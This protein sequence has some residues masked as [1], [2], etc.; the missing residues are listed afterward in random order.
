MAMK[1]KSVIALTLMTASGTAFTADE[2][3]NPS[4]KDASSDTQYIVDK[5]FGN[6]DT[7]SLVLAEST[8][9]VDA[10]TFEPLQGDNGSKGES[11]VVESADSGFFETAPD[12][13]PVSATYAGPTLLTAVGGVNPRGGRSPAVI[14]LGEISVTP[15]LGVRLGHNDNITNAK[16]NKISSSVMNLTPQ[17]VASVD[18]GSHQYSLMYLGD[19]IFIPN[20]TIDNRNT[21]T[22]ELSGDHVFTARNRLNWD[23]AY[24]NGAEARGVTDSS[25][26]AGNNLNP[27][28]YRTYDATGVYRYGANGAKGN[29]ELKAAY[30]DKEYLNNRAI[31]VTRDF[32]SF[33]YGVEFLYR[34]APKTQIVLDVNRTNID[35][36]SSLSTQDSMETKYLIGARWKAMAKTEGYFKVGRG[37]KDF[38]TAGLKTANMTIYES[39]ITWSPRTY[40]VL[41]LSL[42]RNYVDGS[43]ASTPAGESSTAGIRWNHKWK[44]YFRTAASASYNTVDYNSSG[45]TDKTDTYALSALYDAKR[46][47][48]FSLDYSYTNRD[49][50]VNLFSYKTNLIFLSTFISL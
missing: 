2:G 10:G 28:E 39:G 16:R 23:V 19:L 50:N 21:H 29:I 8:D 24:I 20:S 3:A 6:P 9:S 34:A 40:S 38:D 46:W 45:R 41:N 13:S 11:A 44:S 47:L 36:K 27:D 17:I 4:N 7:E 12:T 49:S 1:I 42:A 35:Y 14:K 33:N 30:L 22:V 48:G 25:R 43:A 32:T 37:S 18:R 15:T 5:W 26:L 31:N